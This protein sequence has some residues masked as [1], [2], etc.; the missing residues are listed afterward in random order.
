MCRLLKLYYAK[1]MFLACFVQ[2]LSKKNLW[3]QLDPPPPHLPGKGRVN[4]SEGKVVLLVCI[5]S[6][7]L[8]SFPARTINKTPF[9]REVT[10]NNLFQFPVSHQQNFASITK[11]NSSTGLCLAV[12]YK[13]VFNFRD[14]VHRP[15]VISW[16]NSSFILYFTQNLEQN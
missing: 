13:L 1:L 11:C 2:K 9:N 4:I 15:S 14:S 16:T 6:A 5:K 10:Q 8:M 3:G 12:Y 7:L